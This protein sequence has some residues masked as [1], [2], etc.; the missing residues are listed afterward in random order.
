MNQVLK[1]GGSSV[2]NAQNIRKVIEIVAQRKIRGKA[3]VV[4]SAMGGTTDAL[5]NCGTQ[6]A[7]GS[8]EFKTALAGI[9]NRHLETVKGTA[10]DSAPE[11]YIEY[12]QKTLQ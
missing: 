3:I 1:F 10:P 11:R 12:G 5:L 6:A 4:V 7:S 8:E 9:E 2:A